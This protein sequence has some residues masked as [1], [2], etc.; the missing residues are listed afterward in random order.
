MGF[1]EALL[2][3]FIILKLVG[4]ITWPWL[5]VLAPIYFDVI[6]YVCLA[7]FGVG[8]FRK[9]RKKVRKLDNEWDTFDERW[10]LP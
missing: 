5:L 1:V 3:A 10:H 6:L 4:V 7:I 2:L 9:H 8:M